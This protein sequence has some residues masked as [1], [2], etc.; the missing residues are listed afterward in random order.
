MGTRSAIGHYVC[1]DDGWHDQVEWIYCHWD[2]YYDWMGKVLYTFY[3]T[4]ARVKALIGL[5][6]LSSLGITLNPDTR[7]GLAKEEYSKNNEDWIPAKLTIEAHVAPPKAVRRFGELMDEKNQVVVQFKNGG[8]GLS[9]FFTEAYYRDRQDQ[10][11]TWEDCA[12][13]RSDPDKFW[14][15]AFAMGAEYVYLWR[16]ARRGWQCCRSYGDQEVKDLEPKLW[17]EKEDE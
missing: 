12:P 5:G 10:G 3:S 15:D 13:R 8:G 11:E 6:F 17:E 16:G 2:G 14:E 1:S 7:F 4:D 9:M